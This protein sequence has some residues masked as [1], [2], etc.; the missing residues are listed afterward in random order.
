VDEKTFA[1]LREVAIEFSSGPEFTQCLCG[2]VNGAHN[3]NGTGSCN[4]KKCS[5]KKFRGINRTKQRM[6]EKFGVVLLGR[7]DAKR[8]E[9]KS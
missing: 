6:Y 4:G 8:E 9:E 7:L 5:C 3:W 2:H 1:L